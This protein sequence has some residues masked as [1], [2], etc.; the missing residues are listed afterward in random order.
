MCI[1]C[2]VSKYIRNSQIKL[3]KN[4]D[5][6]S[7]ANPEFDYTLIGEKVHEVIGTKE[8]LVWRLL[9]HKHSFGDI[10]SILSL[11][12]GQFEQQYLLQL[13]EN[14]K[15]LGLVHESGH[16]NKVYKEPFLRKLIWL[17]VTFDSFDQF[18]RWLYRLLFSKVN[19]KLVALGWLIV[20]AAGAS[21]YADTLMNGKMMLFDSFSIPLVVFLI[22]V[23][24]ICLALHELGHAMAMKWA[25]AKIIRGGVA[26]YLGLPIMFVDT[27]AVWAKRR[28]QRVITASAGIAVNLTICAL[29]A[30]AAQ[31]IQ[32][33]F[34]QRVVWEIFLVNTFTIGLSLIPFIKLDGYY[35]LIDLI[36]IPNL[37]AKAHEELKLLTKHPL[38]FQ[39]TRHNITLAIFGLLSSIASVLL[40]LFSISYWW[41]LIRIF[42]GL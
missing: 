14:W 11:E 1:E 21:A 36:G 37:S 8:A 28:Y 42:L 6:V 12:T 13:L 17:E 23:G 38:D 30:L 27:T 19:L 9:A 10:V 32:D 34:W 39:Y 29:A 16:P 33:P 22:N 41:R 18:A 25:K 15:R 3:F 4:A 31:F 5:E 24:L 35:I 26:L 40:L 7:R 20:I 2:A